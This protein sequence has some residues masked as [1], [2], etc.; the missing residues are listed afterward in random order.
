MIEKLDKE[1]LEINLSPDKKTAQIIIYSDN[2]PY[3][4]CE[5]LAKKQ[6]I[7]L[8]SDLLKLA[9]EMVD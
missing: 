3:S 1:H 8:A 5:F 6:A 2:R 9:E 4:H 7:E